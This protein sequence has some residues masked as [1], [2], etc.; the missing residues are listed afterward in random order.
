MKYLVKRISN[1][2]REIQECQGC[3]PSPEL[4]DDILSCPPEVEHPND[5]DIVEEIDPVFGN[6]TRK[7]IYNPDRKEARLLAEQQA[8][9]AHENNYKTL[10]QKAYPTTKEQL[11]MIYWDKVN[12]TEK[13][14]ELIQNIKTKYPKN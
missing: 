8:R 13:W 1:Q 7:V 11:D 3:T 12:G 5:C 2:L 14:V 6:T 9:E 4:F 10:R